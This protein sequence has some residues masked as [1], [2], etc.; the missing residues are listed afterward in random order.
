MP[1]NS[2]R[3]VAPSPA[4]RLGLTDVEIAAEL[5]TSVTWVRHDR[6]GAR[7]LPFYKMGGLVRYNRARVLQALAAVEEGGAGFKRTTKV[8]G[9]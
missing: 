1:K 5:G 7:V 9:A 4:D 8:T 3:V 6:R 2:T